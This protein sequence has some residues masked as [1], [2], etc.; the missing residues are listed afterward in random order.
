VPE[1]RLVQG[2]RRGHL[3]LWL[4]GPKGKGWTSRKVKKKKKNLRKRERNRKEE[5]EIDNKKNGRSFAK[6]PPAA[7]EIGK[8]G[9]KKKRSEKDQGNTHEVLLLCMR[10]S[11]RILGRKIHEKKKKRNAEAPRMLQRKGSDVV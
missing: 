10:V 6:K 11:G 5:K 2:E 3:Y 9:E 8:I 1:K 4:S 7:E